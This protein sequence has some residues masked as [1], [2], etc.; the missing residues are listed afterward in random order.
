[1]VLF[2]R[3]YNRHTKHSRYY[4]LGLSRFTDWRLVVGRGVARS[5]RLAELEMHEPT[6][7]V[8]RYPELILLGIIW[9]R[10]GVSVTD[11]AVAVVVATLVVYVAT[12]TAALR[13]LGEA[14]RYIE[15][16]LWIVV[17]LMLAIEAG[18]GGVPLSLWLFTRH[19]W[20]WSPVAN[21]RVGGR[22]AFPTP[23]ACWRWWR[24][25]ASAPRIP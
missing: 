25:C 6:R 13:H 11:P 3:A 5:Q 4:K 1:M 23:T 22:S 12:S 20:R 8:F 21:G 9:I 18:D 2:S 15:F 10:H 17:P 19:G 24:R 16:N 14:N 7:I